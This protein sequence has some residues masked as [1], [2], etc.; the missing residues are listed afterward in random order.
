MRISELH[1]NKAECFRT[2][3]ISYVQILW[4]FYLTILLIAWIISPFSSISNYNAFVLLGF[5]IL[6]LILHR[7]TKILK[8]CLL[9]CIL[10]I[11]SDVIFHAKILYSLIDC[12]LLFFILTILDFS[13]TNKINH[14]TLIQI[15]N[16]CGLFIIISLFWVFVPNSLISGD[17]G[18]SRYAG[19]FHAVNFSSNIFAITEICFWEIYKRKKN[20]KVLISL[21]IA[22]IVYTD[23]SGTR[24]LL[25]FFPYWLFQF[26]QIYYKKK[27]G[28]L[29]IRTTLIILCCLLPS[30]INLLIQKLRFQEGEASMATRAVLYEQL[31]EG[32]LP[33]FG[34]IPHG[35]NSA[36]EMIEAF[37]QDDNYSPH[38]NFL[39]YLYD[40]GIIFIML[41][42]KI[43]AI[44]KKNGLMTIN[45]LL[46]LLGL[47]SCALHNM[48]FSPYLWIP[49]C[50]ILLINHKNAYEKNDIS[51]CKK[52]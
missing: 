44:L 12:A 38:N 6:L 31:I 2:I 5:D 3:K 27:N 7:K 37:T 36:Q 16:T 20:I 32:I 9:L 10:L 34:F 25:F 14:Q 46:I 45:L 19:I 48:L 22:L 1:L 49:V 33:N 18:S 50:I 24:S 13:I 47:A 21:M 40:W 17:D 42:W 11:F 41:C 29:I 52:V 4:Y 26:Y 15:K 39:S 35:S 30:I 23:L 43:F 8:Y 28:K 51:P